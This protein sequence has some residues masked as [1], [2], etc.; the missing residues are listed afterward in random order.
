MTAMFVMVAAVAMAQSPEHPR[1]DQ[2]GSMK[3]E[4]LVS[5][6]TSSQKS[7]IDA[8]TRK[9]SKTIETYRK[10]LHAVRDSIRMYMD[11]REDHSAVLFPLYEREGAIQ[12]AISKEY[13]RTKTAIDQVLSAEQYAKLRE[14][15]PKKQPKA[16]S[17]DHAKKKG[18]TKK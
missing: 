4:E 11:S 7:R 14:K 13:Y 1:H 15:M 5:D 12:A 3:I 17:K 8:I 2:R 6:L 9:S 18:V 16:K 10:Q